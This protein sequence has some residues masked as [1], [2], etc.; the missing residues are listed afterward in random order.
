MQYIHSFNIKTQKWEVREL[1]GYRDI[2]YVTDS[3][4]RAILFIKS[5]MLAINCQDYDVFH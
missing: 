3:E 5:L 2:V 4:L 1:T